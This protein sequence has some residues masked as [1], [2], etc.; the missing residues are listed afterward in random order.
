MNLK[1]LFSLKKKKRKKKTKKKKNGEGRKIVLV[2]GMV[3][4][5]I[6]IQD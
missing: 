6:R 3:L 5:G 2:G 4:T 1:S